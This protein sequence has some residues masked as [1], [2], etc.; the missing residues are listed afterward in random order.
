MNAPRLLA[1]AVAIAACLTGCGGVG[2]HRSHTA[3]P[4]VSSVI[5]DPAARAALT[6]FGQ[7]FGR[8]LDGQIAAANVAGLAPGLSGHLSIRLSP[9][10]RIGALRVTSVSPAPLGQTSTVVLRD[11]LHTIAV[12]V[13]LRQISDRDRVV[14][15]STGDLDSIAQPP[16]PPLT[17]PKGS[18]GAQQAAKTFLAGY[19]PWLYS[20]GVIPSHQTITPR[21][22]HNL[23][24]AKTLPQAPG[25]P[26]LHPRIAAIGMRHAKT[27][28]LAQAN[29]ADAQRTYQLNLTV[30]HH[31]GRWSVTRVQAPEG[32]R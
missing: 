28:W 13:I 27:G 18:G 14:W 32:Q 7:S 19:L 11:R 21:F 5:T 22:A 4:T 30:T 8:Y 10:A 9:A 23:R 26:D 31:A 2:D 16:S 17:Q 12:K 29:I 1:P 24:N 6:A 20:R 25:T 3:T 15:V